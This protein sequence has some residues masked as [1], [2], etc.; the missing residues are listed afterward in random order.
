VA[1]IEKNHAD[2]EQ[3][4]RGMIIAREISK[5]LKLACS[6]VSDVELFEYQLSLAV[7]PI[8]IRED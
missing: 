2:P 8:S 4:V 6:R 1:W 3:K 7:K 5:D